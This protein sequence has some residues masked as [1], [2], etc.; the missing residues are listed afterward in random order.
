MV[1]EVFNLPAL[2]LKGKPPHHFG[3]ANLKI[4]MKSTKKISNGNT[5]CKRLDRHCF[6]LNLT[7]TITDHVSEI[8]KSAREVPSGFLVSYTFTYCS[9][10]V[11]FTLIKETES[12][13]HKF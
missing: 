8:H 11:F 13:V 3:I 10:K 2:T 6:S 5:S 12:H 7:S 9:V 4:S 1:F